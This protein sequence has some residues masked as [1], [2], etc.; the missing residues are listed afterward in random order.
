MTMPTVWRD[1]PAASSLASRRGSTVSEDDVP[2][3]ISSSSRRR[4]TKRT[5]L[6]PDRRATTPSTPNTNTAHVPQNVIISRPRSE[7]RAP[8]DG[9]RVGHAAERAERR[10]PH[11]QADDAEDDVRQ[12]PEHGDD[13]LALAVAQ[14][15]D[16]RGDE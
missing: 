13:P 3:M 2:R 1:A 9:H 11:D 8:E 14:E 12:G 10:R 4:R 15:G 5:M 6:N 16:G 7:G